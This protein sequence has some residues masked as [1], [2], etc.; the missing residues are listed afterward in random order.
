MNVEDL[1]ADDDYVDYLAALVAAGEV[2][3]GPQPG[4]RIAA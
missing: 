1:L 4:A 2:E 3:G